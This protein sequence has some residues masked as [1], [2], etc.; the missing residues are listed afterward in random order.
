MQR[1]DRRPCVTSHSRSHTARLPATN[2]ELTA[3]SNSMH[4]RI[5][6]MQLIT[7]PITMTHTLAFNQ[8]VLIITNTAWVTR[9][10]QKFQKTFS[11]PTVTS[12]SVQTTGHSWC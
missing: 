8:S 2:W 7:N 1:N 12:R 6:W 9:Y 3:Q 5:Q 10:V 11:R 4:S